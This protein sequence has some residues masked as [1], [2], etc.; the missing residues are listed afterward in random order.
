M[1]SSARLECPS[2]RVTFVFDTVAIGASNVL[3]DDAPH[4]ADQHERNGHSFFLCENRGLFGGIAL[5][6]VSYGSGTGLLIQGSTPEAGVDIGSVRNSSRSKA[7]HNRQSLQQRATA[8]FSL[9]RQFERGGKVAPRIA[10]VRAD[11]IE[12]AALLQVLERA[13]VDEGGPEFFFIDLAAEFA[14]VVSLER[15]ELRRNSTAATIWSR[16]SFARRRSSR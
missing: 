3:F 2:V 4:R 9:K 16:P 14:S 1:V 13:A 7:A 10:I 11:F 12:K 5:G 15:L 6:E 8:R